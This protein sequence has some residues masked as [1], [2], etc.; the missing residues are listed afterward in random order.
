VEKYDYM[1]DFWKR[2]W[3]FLF[4]QT[5]AL[6]FMSVVV[7]GMYWEI[8]AIKD[9]SKEERKEIRKECA[10][11]IAELRAEMR[12]CREENDTLRKEAYNLSKENAALHRRVAGVEARL[13]K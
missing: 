6:V 8:G 3:P 1:A 11:S 5:P 10:E 7:T 13:R 2:F 12:I 9:A 4:Q